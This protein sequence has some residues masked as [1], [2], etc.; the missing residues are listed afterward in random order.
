MI[1]ALFNDDWKVSKIDGGILGP[2]IM[3]FGEGKPVTLPHDA[4][5]E[6]KPRADCPNGS[7]T[8][9]YPG[10]VYRYAK[11]FFAPAEWRNKTENNLS[12][13]NDFHYLTEGR[14]KY[15]WFNQSGREQLFDLRLTTESLTICL[16]IRNINNPLPDGE[17]F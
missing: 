2:Q 11:H 6:E 16:K 7:S 4:M 1:K 10:G 13:E 5:I 3:G 9:Y 17:I 14:M 12:F 15:I 8:G